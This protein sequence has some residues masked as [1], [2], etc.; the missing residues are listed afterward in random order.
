MLRD[1][2]NAILWGISAVAIA[3][4]AW[5]IH[6][7]RRDSA[8]TRGPKLSPLR[9][10]KSKHSIAGIA[11]GRKGQILLFHSSGMEIVNPV[12]GKKE[13]EWTVPVP[14]SWRISNGD[15]HAVVV[16]H[17]VILVNAEGK[18]VGRYVRKKPIWNVRFSPDG[19]L[20]LLN[21]AN[22][23]E[24]FEAA[25]G[26]LVKKESGSAM[27]EGLTNDGRLLD[28]SLGFTIG[29]TQ[30][31]E[32][33]FQTMDGQAVV[34][35]T[36]EELQA[37]S[38]DNPRQVLASHPV[39]WITTMAE[40]GGVVVV[41]VPSKW[42]FFGPAHEGFAYDIK[43]K[44]LLGTLK[45]GREQVSSLKVSRDGEAVIVSTYDGSFLFDTATGQMLADF[46]PDVTV[47]P[48]LALIT[49][50]LAFCAEGNRLFI[51]P[52]WE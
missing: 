30:F 23:T 10:Y 18:E 21:H 11:E 40:G 24:V 37:V 6:E 28:Q 32:D 9:T 26:K 38:S 36:G 29:D 22:T 52:R 16:D 17:R 50:N 3:A 27:A 46:S 25:S 42:D 4:I 33:V 7:C 13:G 19:K 48:N 44:K 51:Y 43:K 41:A 8:Y 15:I 39:N 34:G 1:R 14:I 35:W 12:T 2:T 47:R 31:R 20:F 5:P 45:W 49:D